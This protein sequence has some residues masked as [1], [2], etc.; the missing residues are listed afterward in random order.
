M[1][2]PSLFCHRLIQASGTGQ[3]YP[4]DPIYSPMTNMEMGPAVT[5]LKSIPQ[6]QVRLITPP[7][8]ICPASRGCTASHGLHPPTT[9]LTSPVI[10]YR[11]HAGETGLT[12]A[13]SVE[14]T[15]LEPMTD[16]MYRGRI[17]RDEADLL[18]TMMPLPGA[19]YFTQDD[20]TYFVF[21]RQALPHETGTYCSTHGI[22]PHST[23][24]HATLERR[25]RSPLS[26]PNNSMELT[27]PARMLVL[28]RY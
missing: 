8:T 2:S 12:T 17:S 18:R 23:C 11:A 27:W 13:C 14:V 7:S 21:G 25:P 5:S 4:D 22:P 16:P 19:A 9:T 15:P 6:E 3:S 20:E 26:P 1:R 28:A 24:L 10:V